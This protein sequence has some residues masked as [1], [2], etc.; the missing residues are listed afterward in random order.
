MLRRILILMAAALALPPPTTTAFAQ[1][2]LPQV[3]SSNGT[4]V[5]TTGAL[6]VDLNGNAKGVPGNP[7][8][9]TTNPA[10]PTGLV[11]GYQVMND[12]TFD[13]GMQGWVQLFTPGG[14]GASWGG[15]SSTYITGTLNRITYATPR[16]MARTPDVAAAQ[17]MGIKRLS[18]PSTS[19]GEVLLEFW[20]H[21]SLVNLDVSRPLYFWWGVDSELANGNRNFCE[22]AW[23]NYNTSSSSRPLTFQYQSQNG[24]WVNLPTPAGFDPLTYAANENKAGPIAYVALL[25]NTATG[26]LDGF[27]YDNAGGTIA[28]GGLAPN[29]YNAAS[30]AA[31]NATY[32]QCFAAGNVVSYGNGLNPAF[33]VVNRPDASATSASIEIFHQ[34]TTN[35]SL[36]AGDKV[37]YPL[38]AQHTEET[39]WLVSNYPTS[40]ASGSYNTAEIACE[41]GAV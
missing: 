3:V 29:G 40:G 23:T 2:T 11:A 39:N 19:G 36:P 14:T 25:V 7:T 4:K 17:I 34:R 22:V 6:V 9:T 10:D 15:P 37:L 28:L 38:T 16:L 24:T 8:T 26:Y 31:F 13:A 35:L 41:P 12:D 27:R 33:G 18:Q 1:A 20:T 5:S 32:G 30:I 21:M